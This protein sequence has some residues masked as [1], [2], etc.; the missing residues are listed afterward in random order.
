MLFVDIQVL[1]AVL[2]HPQ[3]VVGVIDGKGGGEAQLLDVPAQNT[4]TGGV[5]GGGPHVLPGGAQ[6]PGQ[7][8]LQLSGGLVGKGDG[9]DGPGL[10]GV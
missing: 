6:H 8:V 7:A 3:G 4:H 1:Q 5:E 10:G 9:Q 2:H